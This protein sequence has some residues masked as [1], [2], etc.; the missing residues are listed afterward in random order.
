VGQNKLMNRWAIEGEI[1]A[2]I[3]NWCNEERGSVTQWQAHEITEAILRRLDIEGYEILSR[4]Q[5]AALCA[6][7]EAK[8]TK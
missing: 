1:V 2:A 4:D 7:I 5:V 6:T 8:Q 3:T